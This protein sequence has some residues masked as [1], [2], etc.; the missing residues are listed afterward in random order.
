[1][2][3]KAEAEIARLRRQAVFLI[4]AIHSLERLRSSGWKPSLVAELLEALQPP[5]AA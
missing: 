1:V 4:D 2:A 3:S 5:S